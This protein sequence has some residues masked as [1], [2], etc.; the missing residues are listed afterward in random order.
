MPT[1]KQLANLKP[2]PFTSKDG[3]NPSPGSKKGAV[4]TAKRLRKVVEALGYDSSAQHLPDDLVQ[5]L[6]ARY[7][8][9]PIADM[10]VANMVG[11]ALLKKNSERAIEN[12]MNRLYGMPS[13][14]L[15]I[16]DTTLAEAAKDF[17]G[18]TEEKAAEMY[19]RVARDATALTGKK[20]ADGDGEE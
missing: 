1:P 12:I 11:N 8:K 3:D 4:H 17:E 16:V 6:E 14:K 10:L 2:R 18:M 20:A 5:K 19:R 15:D 7:G 13:Q 9:R